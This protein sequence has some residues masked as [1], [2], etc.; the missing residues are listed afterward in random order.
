MAYRVLETI[1]RIQEA[2]SSQDVLDFLAKNLQLQN[3]GCNFFMLNRF[4]QPGQR[5]EEAN[6]AHRVPQEWLDQ[7]IERKLYHRDPAL[8]HCRNT[9]FPFIWSNAPFNV[10]KEPEYRELVELTTDFKIEDGL[11]VPISSPNG[12]IGNFWA[13]GYKVKDLERFSAIISLIGHYAFYRLQQLDGN[14]PPKVVLSEREKEILKWAAVGKTAW[15]IG[16]I[17]SI[18]K[19]TV[20]GNF[21]EAAKKLGATNKLQAVALALS[22]GLIAI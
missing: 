3:T 13:G 9:L 5:F 2:Q 14:V 6:L 19:R 18:S 10:E 17:L 15:E 7:L 16:T 11:M 20:E 1:E 22:Q 4:P 21:T 8:R 12:T